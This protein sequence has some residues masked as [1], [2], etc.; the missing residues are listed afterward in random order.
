MEDEYDRRTTI[1]EFLETTS[2][3]ALVGQGSA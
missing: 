1:A 3:A 2:I